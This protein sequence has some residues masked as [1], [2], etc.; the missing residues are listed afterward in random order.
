MDISQNFETVLLDF[1]LSRRHATTSVSTH[2]TADDD[3]VTAQSPLPL[4]ISTLD[5]DQDYIRGAFC[6]T[7]THLHRFV[8]DVLNSNEYAGS[9]L[10]NELITRD[11]LSQ[12]T[13]QVLRMGLFN[14]NELEEIKL[15]TPEHWSRHSL[16]RAAV[17][18]IILLEIF[19]FRRYRYR[20]FV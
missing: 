12:L 7:N 18:A 5:E 17:E 11:Y 6:Q 20:A 4:P 9:P 2:E 13:D 1:L 19:A 3:L 16:L 8:T 15:E 10:Y 14:F